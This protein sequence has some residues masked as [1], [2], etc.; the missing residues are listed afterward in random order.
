MHARKDGKGG[1]SSHTIRTMHIIIRSALG[2]A[3]K[4]QLLNRNV[5][6]LADPPT[7]GHKEIITW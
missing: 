6:E 3:V 1:L 5:A 7:L 2:H 4:W